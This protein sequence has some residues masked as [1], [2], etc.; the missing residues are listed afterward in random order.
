MKEFKRLPGSGT[1]EKKESGVKIIT[2][3]SSCFKSYRRLMGIISSQKEI[4]L[5]EKKE[6]FLYKSLAEA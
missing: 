2:A 3:S 5:D 4:F 6:I 1:L